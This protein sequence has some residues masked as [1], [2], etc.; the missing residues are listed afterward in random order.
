MR[1]YFG[2]I[3]RRC[4]CSIAGLAVNVVLAN[5]P[6]GGKKRSKMVAG[7]QEFLIVNGWVLTREDLAG[8][9]MTPNV[10]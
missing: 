6:F 4:F 2:I 5:A 9:K 7:N 3:D 8:T 1:N 10:V